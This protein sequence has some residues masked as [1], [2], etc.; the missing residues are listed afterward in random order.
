MRATST[1]ASTRATT[2]T[3]ARRSRPRKKW[4]KAD[5]QL[6]HSPEHAAAWLEED[7]Y[8]FRLSAYRER[9]LDYYAAHPEFIQPESR[10]NEIVNLVETELKDV[11]I[12]RKGFTWG[13]EVPF[14]PEPDDLRLVRRLAELHHGHRLRN[15]MKSGSAASGRPTCT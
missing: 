10:R 7:N 8:Y 4:P 2:A 1:K 6:P 13:I 12:T 3:A 11:A 14:D 9:L 15:A 5:G